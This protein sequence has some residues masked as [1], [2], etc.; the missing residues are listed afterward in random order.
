MWTT[1]VDDDLVLGWNRW[2]MALVGL[3][4]LDDRH[5]F[6]RDIRNLV[7]CFINAAIEFFTA[8]SSALSTQRSTRWPEH[9]MW[10]CRLGNY[11]DLVYRHR[12][13][14]LPRTLTGI[15]H[16][17]YISFS[18]KHDATYQLSSVLV[19][20]VNIRRTYDSALH[21]P[22]KVDLE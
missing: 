5:A 3:Q 2:S 1:Y 17:I 7:G 12:P 8:E 11:R 4:R 22:R 15:S 19:R 18:E 9:V 21:A 10:L 20:T 6:E 14:R 16:H 13:P